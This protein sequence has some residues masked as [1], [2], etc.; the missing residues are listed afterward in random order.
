[1]HANPSQPE[2][3]VVF[4]RISPLLAP[5]TP[6]F[7]RQ[8]RVLSL[9][10]WLREPHLNSRGSPHGGFLAGL[11]D[12]TMGM[13]CALALRASGGQVQ[14]LWTTSLSVDY[15]GVAK[16][17]QWIAF[18]PTFVRPGRTLSN[19]ELDITADGET[20]ARARAVFRGRLARQR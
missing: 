12:Q 19:A 16:A 18:T 2:G 11:A 4:D 5:W 8:D 6:I 3:F 1:M 10:V 7:V 9:G 17:G 13:S 20:I 14:T 15:L